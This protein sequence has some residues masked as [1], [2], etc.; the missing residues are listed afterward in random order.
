[1][2]LK[3]FPVLVLAGRLADWIVDWLGWLAGFAGYASQE[4]E[5][6]RFFK[7]KWMI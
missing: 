4:N 2:D 1:M 6:G 5:L 3:G 7:G